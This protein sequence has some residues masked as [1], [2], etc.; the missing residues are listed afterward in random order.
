M[1]SLGSRGQS[2][3][4]QRADHTRQ[5][6]PGTLAFTRCQHMQPT[7]QLS[8]PGSIH[9]AGG[10]TAGTLTQQPGSG[11]EQPR[12]RLLCKQER[13]GREQVV[14]GGRM[15]FGPVS[16]AGP[17]TQLCAHRH[18]QEPPVPT[19][20]PIHPPTHPHAIR[21]IVVHLWT[22]CRTGACPPA[23]GALQTHPPQ[24]PAGRQRQGG[25][26]WVR[27]NAR[28]TQDAS[29]ILT[30]AVAQQASCPNRT[31]PA[32]FRR[33]PISRAAIRQYSLEVAYCHTSESRANS[34][35]QARR[36]AGRQESGWVGGR[37]SG[38]WEGGGG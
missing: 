35:L 31:Q 4:S 24:S 10:A 17:R 32:T 7:I 23:Q 18:L 20:S 22:S 14:G 11:G 19:H 27:G 25:P 3:S 36:G 28:C 5:P 16:A 26:C 12:T 30:Q 38:A 2:A 9:Q 1:P 29:G 37:T 21:P 15:G 6:G 34:P 8:R 33:L 13:P